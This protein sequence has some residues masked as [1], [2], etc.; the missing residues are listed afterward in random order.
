[1]SIKAASSGGVQ[2]VDR[3]ATILGIIARAELAEITQVAEVAAT[4]FALVD[5]ELEVGL[6]AV[7]APVR[8]AHGAH[9]AHGD[10]IASISASGPSFW[11]TADEAASARDLLTRAAADAEADPT[12]RVQHRGRG[13][14][15]SPDVYSACGNSGAIQRMVEESVRRRG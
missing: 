7:S 5:D 10:V 9:G 3:A 4:G 15:I 14:R 12:T 13:S 2:S 1:M 6:T 11:F 8:T